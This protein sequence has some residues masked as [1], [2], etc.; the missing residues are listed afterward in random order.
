MRNRSSNSTRIPTE[1]AIQKWVKDVIDKY[2][3]KMGAITPPICE[4]RL[5][6]AVEELKGIKIKYQASERLSIFEE[7]LLIPVRGGFILQYG[8]LDRQG[9]RFHSVK[10]RETIC[11]ELAHI[12]FYDCNSSI[13]QL[14]IV[15]PEH[16]CHNIARQFLVPDGILRKRLSEKIESD[17]NLV[18][19]LRQLSSEFKVALRIMAQRL[20]ED[21][22]LLKDTMITFWKY[23]DGEG[24][25]F[26][27][28]KPDEQ[29]HCNDFL[30]DPR[31]CPE[32][33]K[34]LPKYW[35]DHVHI[36]AWHNV[37]N[38]VVL[39]GQAICQSSL[40]VQSKRQKEGKIKRILFQ[41]QCEPWGNLS[42]QLRFRWKDQKQPIY[43]VISIEKFD[44]DSL[45]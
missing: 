41:V 2:S 1:E 26:T 31:L 19:L 27:L 15:P 25:W 30:R 14:P 38:K 7:G 13:P 20:T 9:R 11:H 45:A 39:Q 24:D 21:L 37:V 16:I 3:E 44:L 4:K 43:N 34:L 40:Y 23:K 29:I 17:V 33:K 10:I 36:K 8:V 42:N 18:Q 32:L 12:L 22:S 28:I 35:R 5:C 6:E